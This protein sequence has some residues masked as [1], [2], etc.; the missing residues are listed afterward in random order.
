MTNNYTT[1]RPTHIAEGTYREYRTE[2]DMIKIDQY[3]NGE[4][5]NIVTTAFIIDESEK[6]DNE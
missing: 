1:Q 6:T 2:N 5:V 4:W 3:Q